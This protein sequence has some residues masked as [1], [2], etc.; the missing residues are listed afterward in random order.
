MSRIAPSRRDRRAKRASRANETTSEPA[1]SALDQPSRFPSTRPNTSRKSA[2]AK[3]VLPTQFGGAIADLAASG[4]PRQLATSITTPIGT[5]T[6]KIAD[7]PK[8]SVSSPPTSGPTAS[9]A[10]I[11]AP[12][13]PSARRRAG[14]SGSCPTRASALANR[15][16]PP[17]PWTTRPAMSSATEPESDDHSDPAVKTRRPAMKVFFRPIRSERRPDTKR[18]AAIASE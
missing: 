11:A 4:T 16:A 6:R 5:L 12:H 9:P 14:P 17:A 13:A 8:P 10:P 7:Q 1:I 18:R 2:S 15:A 3:T